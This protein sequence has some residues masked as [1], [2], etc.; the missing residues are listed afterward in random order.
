MIHL[1][2]AIIA[3][4]WAHKYFNWVDKEK[5]WKLKILW[6]IVAMLWMLLCA[7][8]IHLYVLNLNP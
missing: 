8:Q 5:D 4:F 2:T 6:G 7:H 3:F 1:F